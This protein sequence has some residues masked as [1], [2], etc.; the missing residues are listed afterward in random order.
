MRRSGQ[1]GPAWLLSLA[2]PLVWFGHFS[3]LYGVAS[4]GEAAGLDSVSFDV[5]AW[6]T[7]GGACIA[8]AVVWHQSQRADVR[9][10]GPAEGANTVARVLAVLSL[11]GILLQGLVLAIVE[12]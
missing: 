6:L 4:F 1:G 9:H 10:D 7:T 2:P 8:V 12:P 5:I 11:V 3:A